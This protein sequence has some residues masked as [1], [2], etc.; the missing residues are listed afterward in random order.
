MID[1]YAGEAKTWLELKESRI[2]QISNHSKLSSNGKIGI[3]NQI[4]LSISKLK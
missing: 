3:K 4:T 1:A 2:G